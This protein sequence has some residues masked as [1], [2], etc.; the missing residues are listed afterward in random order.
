MEQ[1]VG[2]GAS[3]EREEMVET[4]AKVPLDRAETGSGEIR[5][6]QVTVARLEMEAMAGEA[7]SED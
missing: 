7:V 1:G 2:V 3:E 5:M 4:A 6:A